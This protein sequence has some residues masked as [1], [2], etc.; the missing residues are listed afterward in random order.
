M[1]CYLAAILARPHKLQWHACCTSEV[2]VPIYL[3]HHVCLLIY[4]YVHFAPA[5]TGEA[6]EVA[7]RECCQGIK[8]GKILVHRWAQGLAA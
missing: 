3:L 4:I 2:Y 1:R 8:I 6:M 7:L 5:A